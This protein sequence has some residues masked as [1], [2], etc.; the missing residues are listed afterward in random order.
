MIN[1]PMFDLTTCLAENIFFKDSLFI[2]RTSLPLTQ[3]L[4]NALY[5]DKLW[6]HK[7]EQSFLQRRLKEVYIYH[8]NLQNPHWT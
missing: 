7:K 1:M 3:S 4:P 5:F 6:K 8:E 2:K